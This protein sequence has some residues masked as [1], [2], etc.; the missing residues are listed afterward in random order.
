MGGIVSKTTKAN[1]VVGTVKV[2]GKM[3]ETL[4][5][6]RARAALSIQ[7]QVRRIS[8]LKV[9]KVL[10]L[11][12]LHRR[13]WEATVH[14]IEEK[15][16]HEE[17]VKK[18]E[19]KRKKKEQEELLRKEEEKRIKEEEEEKRVN[20][21][22]AALLIQKQVRRHSAQSQLHHKVSKIKT[23]QKN[24]RQRKSYTRWHLENR[25]AKNIQKT[26]RGKQGRLIVC[27]YLAHERF[28]DRDNV[29]KRKMEEFSREILKN[30]QW[31][32]LPEKMVLQSCIR[33]VHKVLIGSDRWDASVMRRFRRLNIKGRILRS[34]F[35]DIMDLTAQEQYWTKYERAAIKVQKIFRKHLNEK[36]LKYRSLM[37]ERAA[38]H[39]EARKAHHSIMV[40]VYRGVQSLYLVGSKTLKH[41]VKRP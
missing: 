19:E 32:K 40:G 2:L 28:E 10:Q 39:F 12:K 22:T 35:H 41:H 21:E 27:N 20:R 11:Q 38:E 24:Y 5:G 30:I 9:F 29:I 18:E 13:D 25:M 16:E 6:I 14:R 15:K 31:N 33:Q 4:K 1:K 17:R 34:Q 23:I 26:F 8:A 37:M 36:R 3:E 7:K